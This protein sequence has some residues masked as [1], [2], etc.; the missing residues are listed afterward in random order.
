MK[1]VF[2]CIAILFSLP[3]ISQT[4]ADKPQ[5]LYGEVSKTNLTVA[6]FDKL[7]NSGYS[8]YSPDKALIDSFNTE[9]WKDVSIE[10]FFGSWCGDSKRE[11]PRFLKIMAE[12]N[13]PDNK[14]KLIAVGGSDSLYKQSPSHEENGKGIFR[15]PTFI[16]YKKG[17][18]IN[19]INEFPVF[20]LERDLLTILNG[21]TYS[22][23]YHSFA[24][25]KKWVNE[26][27][28]LEQNISVAGLA[29]QLRS[30]IRNENE[31]NNLG[32]VL[33]KQDRKREALKIF[34]VN[35][36]LYPE[37]ANIASSLGEGFYENGDYKKAVSMLEASLE[38]NKDP[39]LVKSILEILYKAKE[40]EKI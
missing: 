35:Y 21:K 3:G 25:V 16:I 40:R 26:N 20:S 2:F 33:L 1:K 28:L 32:Y 5:I 4:S 31:L 39:R 8:E 12:L 10:V 30:L 17:R 22:P 36:S 11:V 7:F 19:R 14:I 37:S 15:V 23:N 34:Q 38:M 18:E 24:T 6:P 27:T 29:E 9:K 13:V